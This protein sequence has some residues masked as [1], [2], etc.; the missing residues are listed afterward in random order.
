MWIFRKV[1]GPRI[2]IQSKL[3]TLQFIFFKFYTFYTFIGILGRFPRED[4][5]H[6]EAT[7]LLDIATIADEIL[8][9]NIPAKFLNKL[10][11]NSDSEANSV[12]VD[13]FD[14]I[15]IPKPL[16]D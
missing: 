8:E 16:A 6:L 9:I 11:R 10:F 15:K 12:L 7:Y 14:D 1:S 13:I 5:R 4:Y 2:E 3:S